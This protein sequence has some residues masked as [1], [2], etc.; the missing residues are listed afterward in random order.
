MLTKYNLLKSHT[1]KTKIFSL[2]PKTIKQSFSFSVYMSEKIFLV[3]DAC[4]ICGK[5]VKGSEK[6]SYYCKNCNLLFNKKYLLRPGEH[7]A[8]KQV[9]REKGWLYFI[10]KEG[11]VS[12]VKMARSRSDKGPKEHEKI[13]K[14]GLVKEK[15]YLYY[16]DKKGYIARTKMKRG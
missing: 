14:L 16:L 10:D 13:A 3:K 6:Y 8:E 4:P 9:K 2:F 11:D 5:D 1:K 15:G 7:A 12:R